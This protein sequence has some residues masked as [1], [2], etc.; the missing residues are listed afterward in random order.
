MQLTSK[1]SRYLKSLAHHLSPAVRVGKAG[2]TEAIIKEI[3]RNL[4]DHELIKVRLDTSD[5][6][7]FSLL[8]D[9]VASQTKAAL[10]GAVGRIA[11]LYRPALKARIALP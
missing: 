2:Y 11:M 6:A 3:D 8:A 9:Q 5:R 7:E 10:V 1:Q 4:G